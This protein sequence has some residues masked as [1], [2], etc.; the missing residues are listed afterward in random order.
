MHVVRSFFKR[1]KP[2]RA[3]MQALRHFTTRH[4][5]S[6]WILK[7]KEHSSGQPLSLLFAGQAASRNYITELVFGETQVET[8]IIQVWKHRLLQYV[9]TTNK[10]YDLAIVQ[11]DT[12]YV[13]MDDGMAMFQIPCWVGGER[14]LRAAPEF[15]QRSKHIKSD[16]RRIRKNRLDYRVTSDP[17]EFDRFYHTMYLPYIQR[18]YSGSAFL[19]SYQEM[20]TAIPHC[21]LFLITQDGEDIAGGILVYDD[22]ER[23]RGW[24][25]GVKD[26][27][28][29][30]IRQGA[31]AAFEHLQVGYLLEKGFSRLHRGGS[32][33][34]LNDG[35][36]CFK[37]NRG[38]EIMDHTSQHFI[39]LPV[40]DCAGVRAFLRENPFIYEDGGTL[41]G[42]VFV[43]GESLSE[44]DAARVFH[45]WYVR[46]LDSLNLFSF[47]EDHGLSIRTFGWIDRSGKLNAISQ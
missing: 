17:A 32:R 23:V 38:M 29:Q 12:P 8:E 46:G 1:I 34:F 6:V 24:S 42:A 41:K 20:Q 5:E 43:S 27:D 36:L 25:L 16:I 40:H 13:A 3:G 26:G 47:G 21:E 15:A 45:N 33:P 4:F 9:H 30:W 39:M 22:S 19:M 44:E 35:A 11:S 7:G 14:D 18:I 28:N 37:K 10:K 2:L 31:L